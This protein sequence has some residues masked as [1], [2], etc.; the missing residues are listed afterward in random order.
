MGIC[1]TNTYVDDEVFI[2][3]TAKRLSD[4]KDDVLGGIVGED[5]SIRRS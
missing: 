4:G 5:G 3:F 1:V 2:A